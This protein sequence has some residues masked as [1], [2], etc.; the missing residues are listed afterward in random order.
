MYD[1][2]QNESIYEFDNCDYVYSV[3]DVKNSDLVVMQLN[4]RG[5]SSKKSQMIDL[6]EHSVHNKQVDIVLIS[7]T[8][9][10]E[11]SPA[12]NIPG[13]ELYRQDSIHK[14]GGGVAILT[15]SKLRTVRR[16]NLSSKLEQSE[17]VTLEI[18]LRNGDRPLSQLYVPTPK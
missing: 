17:C 11:F 2:Y 15:S 4:V 16:P 7:E 8:W 14:K 1:K 6:L 10:T 9:L 5:I 12:I 13:Y 18:I 3:S